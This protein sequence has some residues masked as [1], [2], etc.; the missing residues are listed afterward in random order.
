MAEM[1]IDFNQNSSLG[2]GYSIE[3]YDDYKQYP[4]RY[5][6]GWSKWQAEQ[7][8]RAEFGLKGRRFEKY[9]LTDRKPYSLVPAW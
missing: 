1:W 9:D 8:Y 7:K 4:K 2:L 3:A 6:Y 5:Y